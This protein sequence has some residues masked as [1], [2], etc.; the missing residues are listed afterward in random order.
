[1]SK[2]VSLSD[3]LD[4]LAALTG[5]SDEPEFKLPTCKTCHE[6]SVNQGYCGFCGRI[7]SSREGA[8]IRVVWDG[9]TGAVVTYSVACIC[10]APKTLTRVDYPTS[11]ETYFYLHQIVMTMGL[12]DWVYYIYTMSEQEPEPVV[13][14][15]F[16][17][18]VE[19][20]YFTEAMREKWSREQTGA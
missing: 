3:F 10:Q 4:A 20:F 9:P 17:T 1:M 18:H 13:L 11:R 19:R 16:D 12:V 14:P 5:E 6:V 8:D 15:L 7:S 2:F